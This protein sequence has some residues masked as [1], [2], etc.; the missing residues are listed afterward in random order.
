MSRGRSGAA[1]GTAGCATS[2][3]AG[4]RSSSRPTA[5]SRRSTS[6]AAKSSGRRPTARRR[7]ASGD[8][9]RSRVSTS[10]YRPA[11]RATARTARHR[12]AGGAGR[13]RLPPHPRRTRRD[14]PGLRQGDGQR[15]GRGLPA[16]AAVR[17]SDDL[18]GRRPP[19]HRPRHRRPQSLRRVRRAPTPILSPGY[20]PL[21]ARHLT[22]LLRNDDMPALDLQVELLRQPRPV[23]H[24]DKE[25]NVRLP[26]SL[27]EVSQGTGGDSLQTRTAQHEIEVAPVGGSVRSPGCR[28]PRTSTSGRCCATG[29]RAGRGVSATGAACRRRPCAAVGGPG[30]VRHGRRLLDRIGERVGVDDELRHELQRGV[31]EA[32]AVVVGG[33]VA[34]VSVLEP[35]LACVGR[36]QAV[37]RGMT[38]HVLNTRRS[39]CRL[40]ANQALSRFRSRCSPWCDQRQENVLPKHQGERD[41]PCWVAR[42]ECCLV[43]ACVESPLGSAE[44]CGQSRPAKRQSAQRSL[45]P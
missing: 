31:G 39:T 41:V 1:W 2:T 20:R 16:G 29:L 19:V 4:C 17:I 34:V 38:E 32:G 5:A 13:V 22:F 37:L 9:P 21:R 42:G 6:T 43:V 45:E 25:G 35:A 8:I 7:T 11:L 15:G 33:V 14:A 10:A 24:L 30:E 18:P 44:R 12:D 27:L 28:R 26:E 3:S 36:D 23:M 40:L